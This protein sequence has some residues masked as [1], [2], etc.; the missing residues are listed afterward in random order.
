MSKKGDP[1]TTHPRGWLTGGGEM[2]NLIRSMDWSKTPLGP[3]SSW[4]SNL[5]MMVRFLLANRFPLLLWWGPEFIQIYNDPYRPVLGT[6]HPHSMGQPGSECWA[7]IWHIIGPL[8]ETP[9]RGGPATWM[10]DIFLEINRYGFMEETHFT[11][12]YSPVPDDT[13]PGGI[14]GVLAT[15]HEISEKVVGERRV[16]VLRD[17]G[18]RAEA[19]TQE[20]ACALAAETLA[21]H[22]KDISFALIYLLD[23]NGKNAQ[24]AGSAGIEQE[25]IA[26][27]SIIEVGSLADQQFWNLEEVLRIKKCIT[28]TDLK[29]KLGDAVPRGPWS[30]PP[31]QAVVAPI[32]SNV[33]QNLAGFLIIGVSSR[34]ML[35]DSYNTFIELVAGQIASGVANARAYQEEKRRAET[36][37]EL[38]RAKTTFFSNISHEFRTPLTLMLGPI[39]DTLSE[40]QLSDEVHERLEVA[41]RNSLRLL[42]LVNNLL[43]F[44]RIEAGRIAAVYAP[45]DLSKLTADLASVF[46]SAIERA[47]MKLIIDCPPLPNDVYVDTEMW[48]KIVLNLISNAFKFTFNGEIRVSLKTN[49]QS[50]EL[51]VSDTGIGI[52]E[53]EL[54]HIFERFHRV[55]GARGRT[56]EGSGI[57]LALVQ[58][59]VKLHGG[60]VECQSTSDGGSS[61]TVS[62]PFGTAHLPAERIEALRIQASSATKAA[63]FVEEALRWLP[64]DNQFAVE[65][66]SSIAELP[67]ASIEEW[68]SSRILLA[69]DNAD[70]REYVYRLLSPYYYVETVADGEAV[71]GRIR[72]NRP[73][74]IITDV[75]MPKLDGFE[76]LKI[77]RADEKIATIPVILL[78]AR[79]GEEARAEGMEAGADDY[80]TKPFSARELLACVRAH[81]NIAKIR[82]ETETSIR[83]SN[84]RFS[85]LFEKSV[86]AAALSKL[87]EGIFTNVNEAFVRA[88][89]YT[90]DEILGKRSSQLKINRDDGL[91][92]RLAKELLNTGSIFDRELG[93]YTKSGELRTF[94]A[95]LTVLE[96]QR[97]KFVL[98]TL[99]DVTERKRTEERIELLNRISELSRNAND[100]N[101]LMSEVVKEIGRHLKISRC[102]FNEIDL[103]SNRE[104]V[105]CDYFS[106]VPSVVGE[107]KLSEYSSITS[108]EMAVGK[109]VVNFD[110]KIDP[111]TAADYVRT[112]GPTQERSYVAVPLMREKHWVGSLWVSDKV[113]RQWRKEEVALLENIAGRV[114][115]A[116][117]KIRSD[118]NLRESQNKIQ[119]ALESAEE[120]N[121]IKDEFLATISHELRT[122]LNTILG[123]AHM[124][125]SKTSKNSKSISAIDAIY[126][127]AKNQAQ[128]VDD[129]LDIS[130]IINGKMILHPEIV[131]LS[132]VLSASINTVSHAIS[133]KN[134]NLKVQYNDD[135]DDI[136]LYGDAQRLQQVFWNLL[137]NAVK[138]TPP[139]GSIEILVERSE[140]EVI[141]SVKDTGMGI[142]SEFLPIIFERFRQIDSSTTRK[143][144]GIGLGLS[145]AKHLVELHGGAISVESKG[146]GNGSKFVVALPL[147][148]LQIH[149]VPDI[150]EQSLD[151]FSKTVFKSLEGK[152]I[153]LV[154]DDN[155]T[156]KLITEL[157]DASS[158]EFRTADSAK[159]GLQILNQWK[160]N[161]LI[162]DIAMPENDGYWL[163]HQIRSLLSE[164]KNIPAIALTA[165]ASVADRAKVLSAGFQMFVPKPVVPLELLKTVKELLDRESLKVAKDLSLNAKE[166]S[167]QNSVLEVAPLKILLVE[168]DLLSTDVFRFALEEK[169]F[170]FRSAAK[171]ADAL[172]ILKDW[173]PDV[174]VSDLGLPDED[175]YSLIKK[176]RTLPDIHKAAI[177]AVA[178]T[179]YGV[180]EGNAAVSAG[181]QI[182]KS[183]PIDPDT[184]T[185]VVKEVAAMKRLLTDQD[186]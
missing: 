104:I 42:K 14:G 88:F 174:I 68:K 83:E 165:Y 113:P 16:I 158:A 46:R 178:L 55:Q 8:V 108:T 114:W 142:S 145:I 148:N 126:S 121:R 53:K 122:P 141:V 172:E 156:L 128:I 87:P 72:N 6:K 133:A 29:S 23:A 149:S 183:K 79:A 112:Y 120:A 131:L 50:A 147:A 179:G 49:G 101:S 75:M 34:L 130:R 63:A 73:D 135:S 103:E 105:L 166:P 86:F 124:L 143:F 4:S 162:S 10:E 115:A 24:L 175:G 17:L 129:L 153:L 110:S 95:N 91:R 163:I 38:D 161:L 151:E 98:S 47:G 123:W 60:T 7:E 51:K 3:L 45:V 127:S 74:L 106:G 160:P 170:E 21:K 26:S 9:Y 184:L 37:T 181:F 100:V 139:Y 43:D 186:N 152:R 65:E 57:G 118:I 171:A 134:I 1:K 66:I 154:D 132:E 81:L 71:L 164:M 140:L 125:Q 94:I 182:F 18:L 157:F 138:F 185:S 119:L 61:F 176:I 168:D 31:H 32:H 62:V 102:L 167:L 111:R 27:P 117:E 146:Q 155:D 48:E 78:S 25:S 19:K 180:A 97:E 169:G 89:G 85:M 107:H 15:V 59:L 116:V 11:I 96:F 13:V 150:E 33:I 44:S 40:N 30:D 2:G 5:K 92:D 58:E 70:M 144:G 77:L 20:E 28:I 12:A 90:K 39:E 173:H 80:L 41:H 52:D 136:C 93:L 137:S 76:L 69:D 67:N 35:D 22:P 64:S 159:E 54:P 177:P 84:E 82:Q 36:L 99:Q 109:T 56:F